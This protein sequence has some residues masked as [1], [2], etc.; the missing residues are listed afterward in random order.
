MKQE[1]EQ[2]QEGEYSKDSDRSGS[3]TDHNEM[4]FKS[5]LFVGGVAI[6][7]HVAEFQ[8]SGGNLVIGTPGRIVD[9]ISKCEDFSENLKNLE[10][11]ILD[12][13]DTLLAMGFRESINTIL[14]V[15]PKQRRT[16]LF[17][18]TQTSEV[19]DLTRAGMRNPVSIA[20]KVNVNPVASG[21]GS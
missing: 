17:S 7:E 15:L 20:V 16:G 9:M 12:E 2:E 1:E 13:A 18:A 19:R 11:L 6:P 4:R 5:V 14:S 21:S 3:F 10:V 8:N